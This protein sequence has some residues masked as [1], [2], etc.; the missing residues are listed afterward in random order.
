LERGDLGGGCGGSF[1]PPSSTLVFQKSTRFL[2]DSS[3]VCSVGPE[4]IV[5]ANTSHPLVER[6]RPVQMVETHLVVGCCCYLPRPC[7]AARDSSSPLMTCS[8]LFG[9]PEDCLDVQ[10]SR[11]LQ[12]FRRLG[13][14]YYFHRSCQRL[15]EDLS[16][17][18]SNLT[19]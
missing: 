5:A 7:S 11:Q 14:R 3:C 15:F 9:A 13:P 1:L 19:L 16:S 18:H 10:N 17:E 8:W 6:L 2:T 4:L 12:H